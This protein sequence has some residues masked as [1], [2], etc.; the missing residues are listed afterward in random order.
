V[1]NF[2]PFLLIAMVVSYKIIS[3]NAAKE[4]NNKITAIE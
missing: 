2:T 3:G 1:A 4:G